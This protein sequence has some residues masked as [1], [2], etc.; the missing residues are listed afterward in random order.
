MKGLKE[1]FVTHF[2][3]KVAI[4]TMQNVKNLEN[5]PAQDFA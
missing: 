4:N 3:P 5:I 2:N 1:H